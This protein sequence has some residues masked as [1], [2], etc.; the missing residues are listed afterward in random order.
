MKEQ[1]SVFRQRFGFSVLACLMSVV[2]AGN[3]NADGQA[4]DYDALPPLVSTAGAND[5]PNVLMILDTSGSMNENDKGFYVGSN[6]KDSKTVISRQAIAR[7][8]TKYGAMA[9]MGLM[10]F[11]PAPSNAYKRQDSSIEAQDYEW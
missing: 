4:S 8:L 7:I 11:E 6:S 2:F 3:S 10:A 5:T 9:N 1:N